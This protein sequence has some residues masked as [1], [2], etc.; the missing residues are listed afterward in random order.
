MRK[1][2]FWRE[3]QTKIQII[4]RI[5]P[6]WWK[7]FVVRMK[8]LHPWQ[9]KT[10]MRRLI[11]IFAGCTCRKLRFLTIRLKVLLH[12]SVF[13][14]VTYS[15]WLPGVENMAECLGKSSRQMSLSSPQDKL[16]N[17]HLSTVVV[18]LVTLDIF[19]YRLISFGQISQNLSFGGTEWKWNSSRIYV[20]TTIKLK[21]SLKICFS[22]ILAGWL[23]IKWQPNES[24][25]TISL[26]RTTGP[27]LKYFAGNVSWILIKPRTFAKTKWPLGWNGEIDWVAVRLCL[28]RNVKHILGKTQQKNFE[29][30]SHCCSLG[31]SLYKSFKPCWFVKTWSLGI[32]L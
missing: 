23:N 2:T 25:K 5:H 26:S 1:R 14:R 28:C 32:Y 18:C 22:K 16:C 30:T 6:V 21:I 17:G 12:L 3:H 9:S 11:K 15:R 20:A 19:L 24:L 13:F 29:V 8:K 27:I 7:I 31:D 4:L 10:Q